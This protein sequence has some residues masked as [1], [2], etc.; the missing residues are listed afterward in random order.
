MS[1]CVLQL[2]SECLT[3]QSRCHSFLGSA[4]EAEADQ[5]HHHILPVL[6]R[7]LRDPAVHGRGGPRA[8][9]PRGGLDRPVRSPRRPQGSGPRP[10]AAHPPRHNEGVSGT[11]SHNECLLSPQEYIHRVGRTARGIN[12]RGHAL[13]ILR[14]E[15][16]GFLRFLKQAKVTWLRV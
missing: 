13:L 8:G 1:S 15:E 5:A 4:G 3:P 11:R 2:E 14:P 9:H 12:G 6:Q 10:V 7:R 16:L